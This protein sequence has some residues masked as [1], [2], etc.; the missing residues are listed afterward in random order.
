MRFVVFF[1]KIMWCAL[2]TSK[3]VKNIF[4]LNSHANRSS[5]LFVMEAIIG[6]VYREAEKMQ[7]LQLNIAMS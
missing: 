7:H 1:F 3:N 2:L 5:Y 4:N 6:C